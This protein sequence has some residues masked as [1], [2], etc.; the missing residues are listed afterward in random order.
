MVNFFERTAVDT[1]HAEAQQ[2]VIGSMLIDNEVVGIVMAQA[3]EDDFDHKYKTIFLAIKELFINNSPIDPVIV[4]HKLGDPAEYNRL[5]MELMQVTPTAANINPYL[6]I[7]KEQSMLR[8][9]NEIGGDLMCARGAEDARALIDKAGKLFLDRPGRKVLSTTELLSMFY[10]N[11]YTKAE[12]L[13]WG[14]SKLDENIY[15]EAGDFVV[16]GGRPSVGKT[17]L[18]IEFAL[19]Q[20]KTK[21]V[22]FFSLETGPLK[23]ADRMVCHEYRL[24]M[25]RIKRHMLSKE[26]LTNVSLCADAFCNRNLEF[27]HASGMTAAEIQS[28]ALSRKYDIIYIDYLQ[29][30]NSGMPNALATEQVRNISIG[31]HNLAQSN[32]ITVISLAQLKRAQTKDDAEKAPS[33]ADLKESGQ[34]EQDADIIM[35]LYFK[36]PGK[37]NSPRCLKVAKNKEGELGVFTLEFEGQF[38]TFRGESSAFEDADEDETVPEQFHIDEEDG[39][40]ERRPAGR[41]VSRDEAFRGK[42]K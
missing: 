33:M 34:I 17:A 37:K 26:E 41:Y 3:C 29:I 39:G 28:I 5:L 15:A 20:A 25:R 18:A 10:D 6:K 38:Q 9:A 35:F 27:I 40:E 30:V 36:E 4:A 12:Y 1:Q 13:S 21:R 31:L 23:F 11:Q 24:D 22:G 42:K 14:I 16:I 8:K 19:H 32:G 7:L 2:S